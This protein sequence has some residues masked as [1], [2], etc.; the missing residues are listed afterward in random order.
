MEGVGRHLDRAVKRLPTICDVRA[1]CA[2]GALL[3]V[4]PVVEALAN[5]GPI[6]KILSGD[7]DQAN[8]AAGDARNARALA[9]QKFL[10]GGSASGIGEDYQEL[11]GADDPRSNLF[12]SSSANKARGNTS[13]RSAAHW[14]RAR[15]RL[16]SDGE[17]TNSS[18]PS[19][20]PCK[21]I[22]SDIS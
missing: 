16:L 8:S 17:E 3:R 22:C 7:T 11:V 10:S 6:A 4:Q 19:S 12:S 9:R 15:N 2:R 5:N 13:E 14:A 1:Y 21:R 20:F 18:I